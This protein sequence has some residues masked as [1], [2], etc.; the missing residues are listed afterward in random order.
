KNADKIKQRH[1]VV[2]FLL[3]NES[4]QQKIQHQIKQISDI[5]RL[6]S[7]VATGK[8]NPREVI[9][10]KNSLEAI[11]PVKSLAENSKNE[12]LK[13]IGDKLHSCELL[14]EKIKQMLSEEA[15]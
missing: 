12:S 10:L 8:I 14:R 3:Q 7:K 15:P 1:E 13:I 6:I 5:E 11:V 2:Q 9:H 4:F